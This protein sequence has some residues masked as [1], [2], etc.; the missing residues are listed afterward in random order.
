MADVLP[1]STVLN[2]ETLPKINE[3]LDKIK[4]AKYEADL[5]TRAGFDLTTQQKALDDAEARLKQIKSVYYPG[6]P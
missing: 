3:A 4:Q 5:A 6:A 2:P 1:Q